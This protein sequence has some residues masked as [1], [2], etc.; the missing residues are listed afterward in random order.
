MGQVTLAAN[1]KFLPT[2]VVSAYPQSAWLQSQL[3]PSGSPQGSA[4][5]SGT[6][7]ADG[8]LVI[9]DL[10]EGVRYFL[11]AATP[12]RYVAVTAKA[13]AELD[14][15]AEPKFA[16]IAA[17]SSGD[18]TIVAAVTGKRIKVISYVVVAAGAVTAKWKSGAGT[19]LSGAMSLAA[20]GGVSMA[21]PGAPTGRRAGHLLQTA[22]G[23]ALVLN[24]GGAVSVAGHV[25]YFTEA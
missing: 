24:L 7:A 21:P 13:P 19:D 3:P 18:N 5:S 9:P 8:S 14:P 15:S 1:E 25:S 16:A 20:N 17:A 22:S 12:D 23:A 10:L 6:V 11:H 2:V 4:T